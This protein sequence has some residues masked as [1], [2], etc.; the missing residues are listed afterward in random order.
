[1]QELYSWPFGGMYEPSAI[2]AGI[3]AAKSSNAATPQA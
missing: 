2:A 1:M 3:S